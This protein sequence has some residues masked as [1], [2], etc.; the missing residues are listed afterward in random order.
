M[1]KSIFEL[2]Q[3]TVASRRD[4]VAAQIK[5]HGAWRDITWGEM[6]RVARNISAGL[7][8]LGVQPKQMVS[9]MSNTRV[10]WIQADLG[11]LGAGATTV[12]VY[13]SNTPDD[14]QYILNDAGSVAVFVEDDA[15][16]KKLRALRAQIPK[17]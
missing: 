7:V 10:E 2:F 13:Q 1:A 8:K 12:P 16:L 5:V 14:T 6:D 3:N 11:I 17:V 9:V 4:K 15:Q